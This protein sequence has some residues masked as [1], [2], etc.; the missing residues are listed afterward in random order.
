MSSDIWFHF[1]QAVHS[2]FIVYLIWMVCRLDAH[3]S[4]VLRTIRALEAFESEGLKK[5]NSLCP[6]ESTDKGNMYLSSGKEGEA[7]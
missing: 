1:F 4:A 7:E 3:V 5:K 6:A 2:F